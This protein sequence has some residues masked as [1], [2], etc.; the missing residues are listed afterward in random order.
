M[1][2]AHKGFTLIELMIVVAI[3]GILAAVAIPSYQN[4]IARSQVSEALNLLS[5]GKVP[6][7]EYFQDKGLW[8]ANAAEVMNNTSGSFTDNVE[9]TSGN[10][11]TSSSLTLTATMKATGVN[12]NIQ[13]ETITLATI[14]GASNWSCTGGTIGTK[15]RPSTCR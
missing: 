14:D 5:G 11:S 4:Y 8:P 9:I 15:Y 2:K 7:G 1:K 13:N 6:M 12:T 10:S 3:I